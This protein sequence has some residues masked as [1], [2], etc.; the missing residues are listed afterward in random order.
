MRSEAV[1]E[2]G[3]REAFGAAY[4]RWP[5]ASGLDPGSPHLPASIGLTNHDSGGVDH[6]LHDW[7][8]WGGVALAVA[9]ALYVYLRFIRPRRRL[10][11]TQ[12]KREK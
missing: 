7:L 2:P 12:A 10:P 3:L 8:L 9:S 6:T 4:G 11:K 5:E 1:A